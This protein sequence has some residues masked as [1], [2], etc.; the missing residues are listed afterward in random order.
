MN[1]DII[2]VIVIGAIVF[3]IVCLFLLDV[4]LKDDKDNSSYSNDFIGVWNATIQSKDEF[5]PFTYNYLW[6]FYENGTAY[7]QTFFI[8]ETITEP[9]ARWGSFE[10]T[11]SKLIIEAEKEEDKSIEYLYS[12]SEDKNKIIFSLPNGIITFYKKQ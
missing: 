9:L 5:N 12:F 3:S 7:F 10:V 2:I 11:E 6:T 4:A 8:N 1:K